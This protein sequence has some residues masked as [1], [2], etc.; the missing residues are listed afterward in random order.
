M[1]PQPPPGPNVKGRVLDV[2]GSIVTISVGSRSKVAVGTEFK[3]RRGS[4]FV[5]FLKITRVTENTST[6]E[7]DE[8]FPGKGAPPRAGDRAYTRRSSYPY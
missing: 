8:R 6:G 3:L 4:Q 2:A 1:P 5:G 7:V